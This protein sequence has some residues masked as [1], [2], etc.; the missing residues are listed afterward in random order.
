[1]KKIV[2]KNKQTNEEKS[3]NS[4]KEASQVLGISRE[5]LSKLKNGKSKSLKNWT[6]AL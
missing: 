4:I 3:F 5:S 1:M 6:L 2:P